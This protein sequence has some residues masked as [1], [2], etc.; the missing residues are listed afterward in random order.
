[1]KGRWYALRVHPYMTL[2]NKIA[3]AVLVAVDIDALKQSELE[4]KAARDYTE[5][6]IR[7]TRNPLLILR[8]DLR[9]NTANDAFYRIFHTKPEETNGHSIFQINSGAWDIPKLRLLLED[10]LPRNS[11]FNDFEVVHDFPGLGR[12]TMLL[13]AR[14]LDN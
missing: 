4:S 13:N 3:G 7:T 6:I 11:F 10:I 1:K 2:D 5:A 14:R 9:V 12:R 8:A